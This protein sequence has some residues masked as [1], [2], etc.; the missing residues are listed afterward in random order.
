MRLS[1]FLV[2]VVATSTT[3]GFSSSAEGQTVA[4]FSG[5][6]TSVGSTVPDKSANSGAK[7]NPLLVKMALWESAGELPAMTL[8]HPDVKLPVFPAPLRETTNVPE[9]GSVGPENWSLTEMN[10]FLEPAISHVDLIPEFPFAQK[11]TDNRDNQLTGSLG[12]PASVHVSQKLKEIALASSPSEM[13]PETLDWEV[14]HLQVHTSDVSDH[15]ESNFVSTVEGRIAAQVA[16]PSEPISLASVPNVIAQAESEV[17]VLVAEVVVAGVTGELEDIVYQVIK[18]QPGRVSTRSQL[19]EDINAIFATGWFRNVR[20]VPEDTPLG[21]RVTFEVQANP[22]LTSVEVVGDE[23][24]PPE[25]ITASFADQYGRTLNLQQFEEGIK[26]LN[27][28]YQDNGYVL[29]QV[30]EAP[31]VAEDGTVT[32]QVVEGVIESVEVRYLTKDGDEVDPDGNPIQGKTRPYI[33]TREVEQQPGDIFN[34]EK[35]QEDLRRVFGLGIFEDVR[36]A[37]EPGAEDPTKARVIVNVIEKSTG[38]LAAG[39]GLSSASGFFGTFSYQQQNLG[40]N[41]QKLGG[42]LQIGER[43]FLVDLRFTDP[44][45]GGDPYRTSYTVNAFRRRTISVVFGTDG[46]DSIR[47]DNDDRPRVV[48]TGGGISFTRPFAPNPFTRAEWTGS[49]G[50]EYQ[51]VSIRDADGDLNPISEDGEILTFDDSGKDDLLTLQFGVVRDRRNNALLPTQ[52]SLV[53][54][55]TE[56]SIPVGSGSIFF[57]RLRASFNYYLPVSWTRFYQQGPQALAFSV[58]GGTVIGD[59]PPY[60]AFAVG[61]SNSVRGYGEGE[62]GVGRSF[63]QG[64][65]EYRFPVTSFLGGVFFVDAGSTL[66]SQSR[67]PGEPGEKRGLPGLG[68]GGGLG[69][70]VQSPVGQIRIDYAVNDEGDSRLHFGIGERF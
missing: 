38:S 39:A 33:I 66:G 17:E 28:W 19:Q 14:S 57:N 13:I 6:P 51:R 23:V 36:L 22:V 32:L 11:E 16:E 2:A 35:A 56:Q 10:E 44:W 5:T 60:E 9:S 34:R 48:R 29:A 1:P 7:M 55:A 47:L 52:G 31:Q 12:V 46:D 21:V 37:L 50:L 62:L 26:K 45:I 64:S 58:Q 24:L 42:E 68:L 30:I 4:N 49:L 63:I 61:G 53:R 54:L 18:T 69:I 67:V 41:N 70:R 15:P 8:K 20:A 65:V 25:V 59:L 40:G 3:L 27:T 43:T